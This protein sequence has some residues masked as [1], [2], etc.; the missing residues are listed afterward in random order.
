MALIRCPE[1]GKE[2]S[3]KAASCPNCGCPVGFGVPNTN[4]AQYQQTPPIQTQPIRAHIDKPAKNS[5]LGIAALIL[6][7]LGIT[8]FISIILATVDL[9]RKDGKKKLFSIIAL[10]ISLLWFIVAMVST[11]DDG[12]QSD[13]TMQNTRTESIQSENDTVNDENNNLTDKE[14]EIDSPSAEEQSQKE[15]KVS[16]VPEPDTQNGD[17][18]SIG[19][20]FKQGFE[21]NFTISDENK[22]NIESIE[23]SLDEIANDEE[24]QEAYKNWKESVKN[25][26]GGNDN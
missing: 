19:D 26:F 1:C 15:N 25:L 8:F 21:Y 5:V 16:D 6:S 18:D 9:C 3:D 11:F 12:T 13:N 7:I 14:K 17:Y 20:A 2:I 22:E 4:N 23:E 24:V 10:V